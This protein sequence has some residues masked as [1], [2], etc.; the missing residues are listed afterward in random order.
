MKWN[1]ITD[2]S[3]DLYNLDEQSEKI[4][5]ASVPFVI[6]IGN[7]DFVDDEK[8]N[9]VEMVTAMEKCREASHTSC[10]SPYAWYEQFEKPGCSIAITISSKLSG[11]YNSACTARNM[12]LEK[13]SD[14][15]IAV[16]DSRSTGSEIVLIVMKLCKLINAGHDFN[17][18][19][20]K[21]GH[22]M[23]H[24]HIVFA[25]S[26]FNN[27]IKNGRMS[28]ITGFLAGKLGFWGIGIGS[29]Q[30]TIIIKGKAR[31]SKKALDI[32]LDDI[33]ERGHI[34]ERGQTVV[35]SHCQNAEF[36]ERLKLA[37][38]KVWNTVEV[39]IIPTRGLCSYYAEK[40]GLII[41]F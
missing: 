27:L 33:K 18:I 20:E 9:T 25:L 7:R 30:G 2:S 41:G 31:G 5:Y 22:Y 32:I 3:C 13:Y 11:S 1:I 29:E 39:K 4:R 12:I 19:I 21:I 40:G 34:K 35:I 23:Q 14:K 36:A 10:P 37:I 15:K 17:S 26:S 8:L 24:T 6:N 38:Q 16:I 28:R